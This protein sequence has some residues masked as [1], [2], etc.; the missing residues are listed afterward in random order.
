VGQKVTFEGASMDEI[1]ESFS[2]EGDTGGPSGWSLT[3][4]GDEYRFTGDMDLTEMATGEDDLDMSAFMEGA[5][6]RVAMT[7]PGE[8]TETNGEADG[9]TVVWEPEI[10]EKND[11]TAVA[12]EGSGLSA[13]LVAAV[14]G[15]AVALLLVVAGSVLV[16]RRRRTSATVS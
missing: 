6:L 3:H 10:G 1:N 9:S 7:F 15:G 2:S 12:Q 11:M 5:E 13:G 4:E 8:V 14:A 16:A